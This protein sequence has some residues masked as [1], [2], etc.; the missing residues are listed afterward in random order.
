MKE[1][2]LLNLHGFLTVAVDEFKMTISEFKL[3]AF[4]NILLKLCI[5]YIY[6]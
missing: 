3:V 2:I 1:E 4:L 6:D 5:K